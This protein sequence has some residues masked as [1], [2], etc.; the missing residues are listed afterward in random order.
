MKHLFIL[1][2]LSIYSIS[3]GD[4]TSHFPVQNERF[5]LGEPNYFISGF[6]FLSP[7]FAPLTNNNNEV[8]FR[9]DIQYLI[10]GQ[11]QN[12]ETGIYIGFTQNSFWNLYKRGS[13][14]Y[15]NNYKPEIFGYW[16][17]S[18]KK[19][20]LIPSFKLSVTHESNGKD[21]LNSRGWNRVILRGDFGNLKNDRVYLSLS[22]WSINKLGLLSYEQTNSNI[23]DYCGSGEIAIYYQP[24]FNGGDYGLG[25]LGFR[26]SSR[27]TFNQYLFRNME[28]AMYINPFKS[29]YW[30]PSLMVQY[31]IGYGENLLDY[32]K[33]SNSIRVGLAI[34]N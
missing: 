13:P 17:L 1:L 16:D 30:A 14:F 2:I 28:A 27:Y 20:P 34:I 18:S 11:I 24:L 6:D 33:F 5:N 25:H 26:I 22:I 32:N 21:S 23:T 9:I 12:N 31:F 4:S 8:K 15:E 3:S 7:H 19:L 10:Y 29:K